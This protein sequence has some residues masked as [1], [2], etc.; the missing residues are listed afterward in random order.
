[1]QDKPVP[2]K[3]I[4]EK[5]AEAQPPLVLPEAVKASEQKPKAK[6][7]A[8]SKLSETTNAKPE[9]IVLDD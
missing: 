5:P 7:R 9:V 4:S 2:D 8:R 3:P 1:V 6:G